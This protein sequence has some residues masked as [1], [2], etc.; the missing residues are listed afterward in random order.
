[1]CLICYYICYSCVAFIKQLLSGIFYYGRKNSFLCVMSFLPMSCRFYCTWLVRITSIIEFAG[2]GTVCFI[3][4]YPG[5]HGNHNKNWV[6]SMPPHNLWLILMGMKEKKMNLDYLVE[7]KNVIFSNPPIR[8]IFSP[9]FQGL[10]FKLQL[11]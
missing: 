10:I 7:S 1:M 5:N 9:N 11:G 8:N 3:I 6:P 2:L 4:L